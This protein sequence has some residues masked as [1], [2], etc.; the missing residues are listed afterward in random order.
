[1][2]SVFPYGNECWAIKSKMKRK[3]EAIENLFYRRIMKIPW[4]EHASNDE[5]LTKMENKGNS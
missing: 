3:H 1:M 5:V 4:N 2:I